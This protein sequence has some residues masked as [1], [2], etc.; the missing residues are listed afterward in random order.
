MTMPFN[1]FKNT[2]ELERINNLHLG[3]TKPKVVVVSI[4]KEDSYQHEQLLKNVRGLYVLEKPT[5]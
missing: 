5:N 2:G 4:N 1:F 3:S